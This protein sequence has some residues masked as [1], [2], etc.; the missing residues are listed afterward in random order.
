MYHAI[1]AH[2]VRSI[3]GSLSRGDPVPMLDSLAPR[4]VYRFEGDSAIGGVR[5][6]RESMRLWWERM[7]RLFPGLNFVVRDVLVAGPP[8]NTRIATHLDFLTT[9]PDGRAYRNVVMQVM[10]MRWGRITEIHTLEDT[11]RAAR[12]LQWRAA[13]GLSEALAPAISDLKWPQTG[14]FVGSEPAPQAA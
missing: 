1:V 4:F 11:Q 6:R 8:W 3:F 12:L 13:Q 9:L 10:R 14:P 2:R 5:T 7:Y